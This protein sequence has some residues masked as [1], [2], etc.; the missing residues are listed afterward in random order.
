MSEQQEDM[1]SNIALN[2]EKMSIKSD[3]L[4]TALLGDNIK[5][6]HKRCFEGVLTNIKSFDIK[7]YEKEDRPLRIR[8]S[9]RQYNTLFPKESS[10][11][12]KAFEGA[13]RYYSQNTT[14]V[15]PQEDSPGEFEYINVV[16]SA[17]V[18]P[19]G[20]LEILFTR[21]ILP[22]LSDVR[23]RYLLMD[24][25]QLGV[26]SSKYSQK[27][28][29]TYTSWL[30]KGDIHRVQISDL[31]IML[32]VPKG[33]SDYKFRTNILDRSNNEI[34]EKTKM[35]VTYEGEKGA[36]GKAIQI[37]TFV[38][39]AKS[40]DKMVP[41]QEGLELEEGLVNNFQEEGI[42]NKYFEGVVALRDRHG[43][44]TD[45]AGIDSYV[46]KLVAI[47]KKEGMLP[48][49]EIIQMTLAQ[50]WKGWP[51]E[52]YFV[53]PNA[54]MRSATPRTKEVD[55]VSDVEFLKPGEVPEGYSSIKDMLKGKN[56]SD[57]S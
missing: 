16:D 49:K 31:R 13:A 51:Q 25:T 10:G 56:I 24:V 52:K 40:E 22:H 35:Q 4:A 19:T 45:Q 9:P 26:L 27:L 43:K 38:I 53:D 17:K 3:I 55:K 20:E 14:L 39:S 12:K 8:L 5:P 48:L 32:K 44:P 36:K 46:E 28:F 34:N 54:S 23:A 37:L 7:A 18:L 41:S 6:V 47:S 29:E 50:G 42:D 15:I 33:Y 1:F 11:T 57:D 21:S 2:D 30:L